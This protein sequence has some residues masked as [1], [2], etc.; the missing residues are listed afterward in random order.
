MFDLH[1]DTTLVVLALL[2][3]TL[4]ILYDRRAKTD[5]P[6]KEIYKTNS[7]AQFLSLIIWISV[8]Y[9]AFRNLTWWIAIFD[10]AIAFIVANIVASIIGRL[11]NNNL[12]F[13]ISII[14]MIMSIIF[15]AL[16]IF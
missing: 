3:T 5:H 12:L 10:L 15:L 16:N 8:I 11:L 4:F 14:S 2:S 13:N 1:K 9:V 7:L 6:F